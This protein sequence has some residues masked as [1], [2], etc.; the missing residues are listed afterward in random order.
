MAKMRVLQRLLGDSTAA[1]KPVRQ[2]EEIEAWLIARVAT[3]LDLPAG[4]VDPRQP[5]ADFGL[6]SRTAIS[7]SGELEEWLGREVPP[8]LVWDHPS[9]EAA[10]AFLVRGEPAPAA[11]ASSAPSDAGY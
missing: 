1:E 8:T 10:A 2:V 5:F 4:D 6:D 9:I 7:I 11:A 3:V